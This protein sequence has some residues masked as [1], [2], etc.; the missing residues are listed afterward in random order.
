[1]SKENYTKSLTASELFHKLILALGGKVASH[2][3]KRWDQNRSSQKKVDYYFE[4]Q[5]PRILGCYLGNENY[6]EIVSALLMINKEN[7]A[8][9]VRDK[10]LHEVLDALIETEENSKDLTRIVTDSINNASKKFKKDYS[11]IIDD[12]KNNKKQI[13]NTYEH[14]DFFFLTIEEGTHILQRLNDKALLDVGHSLPSDELW[15]YIRFLLIH[16]CLEVH[17][18]GN[19]P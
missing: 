11:E 7:F 9:Q 18:K 13:I 10:T 16:I 17:S 3:G 5:Q 19:T 4:L 6:G 12:L 1:M 2:D 8:E 15:L 14:Y